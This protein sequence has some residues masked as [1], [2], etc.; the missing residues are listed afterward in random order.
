MP[1]W[2]RAKVRTAGAFDKNQFF[3]RKHAMQS[4]S[5]KERLDL[6][7]TIA[8]EIHPGLTRYGTETSRREIAAILG[9]IENR[10]LMR[11]QALSDVVHARKQYSTWGSPKGMADAKENFELHN[12]DIFGAVDDY[13]G[14]YLKSPLPDATHYWSPSAL[15]RDTGSPDPY[16]IDDVTD[17]TRIGPHVFARDKKISPQQLAIE[18]LN[19]DFATDA[20]PSYWRQPPEVYAR[21][22]AISMMNGGVLGLDGRTGFKTPQAERFADV[23]GQTPSSSAAWDAYV[24]RLRE[25]IARQPRSTEKGP[26]LRSSL[27]DVAPD[28]STL[29]EYALVPPPRPEDVPL[30][31]PRPEPFDPMDTHSIRRASSSPHAS[32]ADS[33]RDE[34]AAANPFAALLGGGS[35]RPVGGPQN[36]Q[37]A[38]GGRPDTVML[39]RLIR[40]MQQAGARADEIRQA[41]AEYRRR[42]AGDRGASR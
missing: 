16:W 36:G 15:R 23:L 40:E 31:K 18:R 17:E 21:R 25:W 8:G 32:Y 27:Q 5:P 9:T 2:H 42:A 13:F 19:K 3:Q 29:P 38:N 4:L 10:A 35:A 20:V 1:S 37:A 22:A 12:R 7:M 6:A 14:G 41:I 34:L 39:T 24:Q 26:R 28:A 11:K 33:V 30:P